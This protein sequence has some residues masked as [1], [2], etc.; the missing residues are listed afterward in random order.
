M[1]IRDRLCLPSILRLIVCFAADRIQ[2][3]RQPIPE[4][5]HRATRLASSPPTLYARARLYSRSTVGSVPLRLRRS[6]PARSCL[7][8]RSPPP[9]SLPGGHPAPYTCRASLHAP[10]WI[11]ASTLMW[12][13]RVFSRQPPDK[14]R[15]LS[16]CDFSSSEAL[17]PR[18]AASIQF[19]LA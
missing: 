7:Q 15:V 12:L 4:V 3:L 13:L 6:F 8:H 19:V 2:P 9:L 11:N 18:S 5:V 14:G 1:C 17:T 10:F 16:Y